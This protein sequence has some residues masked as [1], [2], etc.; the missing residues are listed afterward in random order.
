[1]NANDIKKRFP[2]ASE[3]FIRANL[4]DGDSGA[5]TKLEPNPRNAP[6]AAKEV[7]RPTG[8]R[9]LVRIEG[10]RK[11]LLDVDNSCE[12]YLVDLLRYCGV[13]PDDAPDK[14][15]IEV[16]QTKCKKG[17]PEEITIKVFRI[18]G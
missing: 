4:S 10:R 3:S 12:K 2:N 14:C 5:V 18:T 8:E 15:E 9:F 17:E 13:I 16:S 11:R 1:L 7:Q 6:L